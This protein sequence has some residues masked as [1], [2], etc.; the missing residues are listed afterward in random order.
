HYSFESVFENIMNCC[1]LGDS[2]GIVVGPEFSR[3]FSEILLQSIDTEVKSK[4][5]NRSNKIVENS[6]YVIKRY[7]DDYF[8]FYN[9]DE[10]RK[11]VYDTLINE[12][13]KYK[14]Y[15]NESKNKKITVP[16]ITG[17]TIA[18]QQ[19]KKL[20]NNLFSKFDYIDEESERMG[21]SSPMNRYYQM[22]NQIIT[23]IKCIVFNNDISY[24]SIT[25]YYFTLARIKVSEIDE[26][27]ED[28][29]SSEEQCNKVTNFLLVII[30]LSFFVHSMDF[31]VRSTYLISQIIILI[32]RISNQLGET[33]SELIR[34]KIY[35]EC[36]LSIRSSIKKNTLKDIECLNLLIAVRD[37][38]LQYQLS[39]D[40]IE[41]VIALDNPDKT[42]Y[43]SLMTCLF[44]IQNKQEYLFTRNK[45]FY[46]ILSKFKSDYFTVINDSELAHIFFDSLRCPYLTKK[47][48]TDIANVAL[49]PFGIVTQDEVESLVSLISE[50]N[51]FIDW[52]TSTSDSIERLLMKKELKAP[53]G[54]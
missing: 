31:R 21:I 13:D 4:L 42:N 6:D 3:I 12:L 37:I 15:C 53:Y 11:T 51:W 20:I 10:V 29:R 22:A 34:K 46:C 45:V 18:K 41:N 2:H 30:E 50:R 49:K 28:F 35:D 54:H 38:D 16:F 24:S 32:S 27:I 40:I 44:Y 25:G 19:Y 23:D 9:D 47:M 8:L 52:N 36:Y 48:K 43:F 1:N 33:N 14:L 26:H 39:R 7:V 5:Y 17:V